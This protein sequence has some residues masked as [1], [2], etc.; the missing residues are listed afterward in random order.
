MHVIFQARKLEPVATSSSRGSSPPRDQTFV[1]RISCIGR[2]ILYYEC[3]LGSLWNALPLSFLP[4]KFLFNAEDFVNP[5][6]IYKVLSTTTFYYKWTP[7][8]PPLRIPHGYS[9]TLLSMYLLQGS[10]WPK[11]A[12]LLPTL[13]SVPLLLLNFYMLFVYMS[14]LLWDCE[15]KSLTW[16]LYVWLQ[17]FRQA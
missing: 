13:H 15:L 9:H 1:S 10:S 6:I 12:F 14:V 4:G 7:T 11:K 2:W 16:F 3:H 17:E 5:S 8:H